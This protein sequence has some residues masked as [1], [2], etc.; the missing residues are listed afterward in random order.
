[1][2]RFAP[3]RVAQVTGAALTVAMVSVVLRLPEHLPLPV[4]RLTWQ[5][6]TGSV[7]LGLYIFQW[8]VLLDRWAGRGG[9][10]EAHVRIHRWVGAAMLLLFAIHAL[11]PGYGLSLVLAIVFLANGLVGSLSRHEIPLRGPKQVL[12]WTFV[13]VALSA[14]LLPLIAL[15]VWVAL[16]FE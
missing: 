3:S 8:R 14:S 2:A 15:H 11:K 16:S 12:V 1:M 6:A 9:R 5:I 10:S 13:H 4:A 7:L